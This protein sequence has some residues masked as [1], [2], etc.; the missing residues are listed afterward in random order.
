MDGVMAIISKAAPDAVH[1]FLN[2]C[3]LDGISGQLILGKLV[4][5]VPP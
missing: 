3:S 5:L 1:H 4:R 2:Q